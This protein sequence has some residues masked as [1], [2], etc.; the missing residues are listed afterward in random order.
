[1]KIIF[2]LSAYI[3]KFL[4]IKIFIL[5]VNIVGFCNQKILKMFIFDF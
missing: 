5:R 1:M 4:L 2:I 3:S